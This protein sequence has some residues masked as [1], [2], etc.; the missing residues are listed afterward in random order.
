MYRKKK[1]EKRMMADTY[2]QTSL[3]PGPRAH[4]TTAPQHPFAPSTR[5][6]SIYEALVH[7]MRSS[8]ARRVDAYT[9]P[10]DELELP[11]AMA[12]AWRA[13]QEA[14]RRKKDEATMKTAADARA[15]ARHLR[16]KSML[17][18]ADTFATPPTPPAPTPLLTTGTADS[19]VAEAATVAL[20]PG[21]AASPTPQPRPSPAIAGPRALRVQNKH[22]RFASTGVQLNLKVQSRHRRRISAGMN[23]GG[24]NAGSEG[25]DGRADDSRALSSLSSETGAGGAAPPPRPDSIAAILAANEDD[26]N[27][28]DDYVSN[29]L[30]EATRQREAAE[31]AERAAKAREAALFRKVQLSEQRLRESVERDMIRSRVL[32]LAKTKER[33]AWRKQEEKGGSRV[34]LARANVLRRSGGDNEDEE[35]GEENRYG[36]Y[37]A[38]GALYEAWERRNSYLFKKESK[39]HPP[40]PRAAGEKDPKVTSYYKAIRSSSQSIGV[41]AAQAMRSKI[42]LGLMGPIGQSDAAEA[43]AEAAKDDEEGNSVAQVFAT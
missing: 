17:P 6:L 33:E 10:L 18:A 11:A 32:R 16:S 31:E 23:A 2:S 37:S 19:V 34:Q 26:D 35:G 38:E 24:V 9:L 43:E 40:A 22:Q 21:S 28:N 25:T 14:Q 20:P 15:R 36:R 3:A 41:G 30:A 1:E 5:E 29:M 39:R 13:E 42:M 12:A 27:A 4:I 8:S 7:A